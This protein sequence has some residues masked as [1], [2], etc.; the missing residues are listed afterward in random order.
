MPA[1]G[2][3]V[4]ATF[5]SP[6][7]SVPVVLVRPRKPASCL[8]GRNAIRLPPPVTQVVNM[9][10]WADVKG[11]APRITTSY[12]LRVVAVTVDRSA[13]ANSLIPS[14]RMISAVK[15]VKVL[16]PLA[17][18]LITR[19]GP[20]GPWSRVCGGGAAVVKDQLTVA[21]MLPAVS[22]APLTV[23]V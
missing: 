22:L 19:T 23:A 15:P 7:A 11:V 14:A 8:S 4:G 21:I 3:G 10:T 18:L 1:P 6:S 13:T 16:A 20:P 12:W 17:E 5:T 2:G 9:V